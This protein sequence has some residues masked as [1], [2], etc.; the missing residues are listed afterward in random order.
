M[1]GGHCFSASAFDPAT[2][3]IA[4]SFGN[5]DAAQGLD[6]VWADRLRAFH[7]ISVQDD[8]SRDIVAEA[9]GS[10]PEM[11]LDPCLLFPPSAEG[12]WTGPDQPFS[13]VYGHNFSSWFVDAIRRAAKDRGLLTVSVSYRNDRADLQWI[14]AGPQ[15]FVTR[16]R[17][18]RRWPP[19]SSTVASSRC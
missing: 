19:T 11:V 18:P 15:D 17:V 8:N 4:G 1:A 16:W 6:E 10:R 7:A 12:A 14:D 5:Y 2:G 13:V 3:V 9:I